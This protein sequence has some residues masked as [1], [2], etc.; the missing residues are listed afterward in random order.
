MILYFCSVLYLYHYHYCFTKLRST[1]NNIAL[2]YVSQSLHHSIVCQSKNF[3]SR[4][5]LSASQTSFVDFPARYRISLTDKINDI[6][7]IMVKCPSTRKANSEVCENKT[8]VSQHQNKENCLGF[9][10]FWKESKS[11]T[12]RECDLRYSLEADFI[13][14]HYFKKVQPISRPSPPL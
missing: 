12:E 7:N 2:S 4:F 1:I 3:N 14:F 6:L 11:L 9:Y 5:K 13:V 8:E 10:R